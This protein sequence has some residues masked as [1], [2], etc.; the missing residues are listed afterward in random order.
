MSNKTPNKPTGNELDLECKG[1]VQPKNFATHLP[2]IKQSDIKKIERNNQGNVV[3]QLLPFSTRSDYQSHSSIISDQH[4]RPPNRYDQHSHSPTRYDHSPAR[5][6]HRS[7]SPTRCDDRRYSPVRYDQHRH[8]PT[9]YDQHS[10]SPTKYD[11]HRYSPTRSVHHSHSPSRYDHRNRSPTRYDHHRHSPTRY[12]QHSHSPTKYDYHS[13]SP[14]RSNCGSRSPTRYNHRRY[15]PTRYDHHRHS[16]TRYDQHSHSPT[17]YDHHRHSPTRSDHRSCA[18]NISDHH[19]H[20]PTRSDHH[21][22]SSTRSD[23]RSCSP[24]RSDQFRHSS[25]TSDSCSQS[26]SSSDY[27]SLDLQARKPTLRLLDTQLHSLIQWERFGLHLPGITETDLQKIQSNNPMNVVRQKLALFG[28]WL[29]KYPSASWDDVTL[30]LEKVDEIYLAEQIK[31]KYTCE[32]RPAIGQEVY[33]SL[34]SEEDV[35]R[36]L[37]DFHNTFTK[38]ARDFRNEINKLVEPPNVHVLQEI[39]TFIKDLQLYEIEGLNEVKTINAFID[40]I[41]NH[42]N[43]LNCDL[44]GLL[45]EEYLNDLLPRTKAYIERVKEF[46][47]SNP[48]QSLKYKLQPFV[49]E[50]NI[51]RKYMIVIV[52]LQQIWEKIDMLHLK[53]L[54]PSLFP[55]YNPKWFTVRSGSICCMFLIPKSKAK[56]YIS[57][58]SEKLQFMRLT[59]IFGLQIGITHVIR[60]DKNESFTFDSA[61]LEAS[62]SGNNEAVQFLLDLGVNINNRNSAGRTALMLACVAR[63]EDVVQTLLSAGA[64]VDIHD[65]AGQTALIFA[66]VSGSLVIICSLLSAKTDPNLQNRNGNT[67]IHLACS[68]GNRELVNLL[69]KFNANPVIP[70]SKDET[71]F[72]ISLTNNSLDIVTDLIDIIPSA[73]IKSAV[74]TSCRLGYPS[75]SSLLIRHLQLSSQVLDFFIA[76]LDEDT[77][78]LKQQLT[79]SGINPNTTLISNIT[80]LMLASSC[81]H[82][83]VL[84]Y[85]IQAEA[86]VNS[87]DEDGYT[88]L[89]YAITGSKSLTIV[90]RLLQSGAN[91]NILVGGIPIIEKAKEENGTEEIVSLLLKYSALQLHKDYEQLPEKVKKSINDEIEE[92][93]LTILQVAEKIGTHFEVTSLTKAQNAHELFNKLQPYYSFLSCDILVDITREFIGGEIENELEG[94]LV[95]MRKFQK[96]VKIKHLKEVMS[97]VPIQHDTSDTCDVNIKLHRE[98]EEGTLENL[99]QLLKHMFHNKQHL[100]NHMTFY[101]RDSLCITFTIPTSQSDDIADEVKRSKEFIECVGVSRVSVGDVDV[102]KTEDSKFS[103][104]SGLLTAAGNGINQAVQYLVEMG[105][106]IDNVN[107][108]GMT[109]LMLASK[110]G[111]KKI[112]E[113][114]LS[115]WASGSCQYHGQTAVRT[116]TVSLPHTDIDQESMAAKKDETATVETLVTHY[117]G[118]PDKQDNNGLTA[119]HHGSQGG[120]SNVVEKLL[121]GGAHPNIRTADGATALMSASENGHSEVVQILLEG[122]ADPNMQ[123]KDGRTALI[124]ASENGHSEV[125]QILLEGSADPN[126]QKKDG[127]TALIYASENGHSEVVQILLEGSADPNTQKKDGRTALIYASENGHSEVVQILLKGGAD[128]NIQKKDGQTALMSASEN[129]HS[130]VIQILLKGGADTNIQTADGATAL[131]SASENGHSKVV[132]ILLKGGADPNMQKEEGQTALMSAS[133]NGHSEVIKILLK[134]GA[135]PN[136]QKYDGETAVIS[137]SQNGHSEVVQIL[138]KGGADPNIRKESGWTALM[139]A[140]EN[141]HSKVVQI[142]LKGSADPNI[143]M[144]DGSTALTLASETG[145]SKVVQI[146]LK[147]GADPSIQKKDGVTALMSASTYGYTE[148]VQILLEGGADPNIQKKDGLTSLM[149]ASMY[150]HSEVV[151]ILFDGGADANIQKKDGWTALVSATENRHSEVVQI[152]LKCGADPN[153]QIQ[154][155]ATSLMSASMYGH[156][157]VVQILLEGGADPNI[158]K[159]DGLTALMSGSWCGHSEVVQILLEGGAD[160]NI[161]QIEGKTALM[162]ASAN[163]HLQVVEI[164]LEGGADPKIK[165]K[166]KYKAL[167]FA[168]MNGHSGVV[169][170]L[171]THGL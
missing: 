171:K 76:S 107:S 117:N 19:S 94:Y 18:P 127:R 119:L 31:T 44:L 62:Q 45:V 105:V 36:Q 25:A 124:Y 123:K 109:A 161:Q 64:E 104:S 121:K 21:S 32:D 164:L 165:T 134:G 79:Q 68:M 14:T 141:S 96:S 132:Q 80:P 101:E 2:T 150:G 106:N 4:S 115:M 142:L 163:G 148:V 86:D 103:F 51:S 61:L 28:T 42:Y 155:G 63:H 168:I 58:S 97:L 99:Q 147:G 69:I 131:M 71:A 129:G 113:T 157:E 5:L 120:H 41:R 136:I 88:P 27:Y 22:H 39:I 9:R 57:S 110:A 3:G 154:N 1:L 135:D 29:R 138:L 139:S 100:L 46:K 146:L 118:D 7:R 20:S 122:S 160:P 77:T 74:I 91:P 84:E 17:R 152:L 49:N 144:E 48:I 37:S 52:K 114:L 11:Y 167:T 33:T 16:P 151:Q 24:T 50:L 55:G 159:K 156:S 43:F 108:S 125:V 140:S 10:H 78:S 128:T 102:S 23:H 35:F 143:H 73:H 82:I 92:K 26:L 40:N 93:K 85:L 162:L 12:D 169:E 116:D 15:S 170:L 87:K 70:N 72:M 112:V 60:D 47:R 59:G 38:L 126:M 81:G 66:C 90:Q 56:S 145:C 95:M 8:S 98:W 166:R 6:N 75:I 158:Q 137:A 149:S 34:S 133:E 83:K 111:H 153:I 30:A 67:A 89:A 53:K 130:E 54:V 65:S 13:H